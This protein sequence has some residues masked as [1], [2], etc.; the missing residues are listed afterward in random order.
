MIFAVD[1]PIATP[2]PAQ[3]LPTASRLVSGLPPEVTNIAEPDL[4]GLP[5]SASLPAT[6]LELAGTTFNPVGFDQ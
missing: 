6:Q 5:A 4:L 3:H 2:A 1:I